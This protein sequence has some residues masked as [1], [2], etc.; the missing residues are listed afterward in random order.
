MKKFF[1]TL[2][3]LLILACVVFLFGWAQ[4]KVPPGSYGVINSKTHGVDQKIVKSGEFRWLW[5]KL[6]PT[7]VEIAVFN[8]EPVNFD[9]NFNSTLPSGDS[10]ASF[11]GLGA[12]FSWELKGT[13]SFGINPDMLV[14]LVSA[15]NLKDQASLD[16][17]LQDKAKNIENLILRTFSSSETDST[18]LENLMSGKNDVELEMEIA[19]LYPEIQNFSLTVKSAKFPD[20]ILYREVRLLYEDYLKKQ[21]E[22]VTAGFGRRAENHIASQLHFEELERYG[23]L[24][25]K[26]PVLLEYLSLEQ[27]KP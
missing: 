11:A 5:Y 15:Y 10:Y 26:F 6:I 9:I 22:L 17:H 16:A 21:R 14:F 4:Y 7:N 1:F 23:E 19:V 24:L 25:T 18:R 20:F 12:N 8:L 3:I 27:K 2:F 13:I